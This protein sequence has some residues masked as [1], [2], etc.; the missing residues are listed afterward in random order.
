MRI[1]TDIE[2]LR[3]VAIDQ[4]GFV[5]SMQ[6]DELGVSRPS[7][8]YLVK[9]GR[10]E[11]V[12]RGIYRVPQVVASE[13]DCLQHSLLWAGSQA[14]LS[15]DTALSCWD[16]SDINPAVVHIT[17]P[18]GRRIKKGCCVNV[19]VHKENVSQEDIRWWDGMRIAAPSLAI[20]QSIDRGVSSHVI[21]Q[22][23]SQ[24]RLRGLLTES[25]SEDLVEKLE[26][27]GS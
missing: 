18:R 25:Q 8:T 27:R 10:I 13:N 26:K 14:F 1:V 3:E 20:L 11:R 7:L 24:G 16:I 17:V 12:D 9:N 22:A 21:S 19:A 15:H 4:H 5:T 2:K 6:A 23:I